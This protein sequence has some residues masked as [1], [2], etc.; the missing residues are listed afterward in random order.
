M[1]NG[2]VSGRDQRFSG[3]SE[4]TKRWVVPLWEVAEVSSCAARVE[5]DEYTSCS[6]KIHKTLSGV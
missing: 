4:E 6:S 5:R 1:G 2:E 3:Q